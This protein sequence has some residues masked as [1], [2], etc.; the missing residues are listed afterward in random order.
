MPRAAGQPLRPIS[1]LAGLVVAITLGAACSPSTGSSRR[2]D[3]PRVD[4]PARAAAPTAD[5]VNAFGTDLLRGVADLEDGN[6]AITPYT[7]ARVLAMSRVGARDR[8]RTELD[9]VLHVAGMADVDEGFNALDA[10][11]AT[12]EGTRESALRRGR[13]RLDSST[14]LWAQE[15][16]RFDPSFLDV[17]SSQYDTGMRTVDFLSDP[18]EATKAVN[19]WVANDTD[20]QVEDLVPRGTFSTATRF[21][22]AS[23]FAVRAP[24]LVPFPGDDAVDAPFRLADGRAVPVP[25]MRASSEGE[26]RTGRGEGWEAIELPYVGG[27]L[28]M[29]VVVPDQNTLDT[30]VDQLTGDELE[31]IVRSLRR[32]PVEVSLPSF[33]FTTR[34]SLDDALTAIGLGVA[35]AEGEADFSGIT[36]DEPLAVSDVP[37]QTFVSAGPEGSDADA[38]TV[39]TIGSGR[40]PTAT[41]FTVDRPFLVVVRDVDT[42]AILQLGLVVDPR[43]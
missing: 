35:F 12:R 19:R 33:A 28:A 6:V 1:W 41:R 43:R 29:L 4:A 13:I 25:T 27:E 36:T 34:L 14:S 24:W 31:R 30:F 5:A 10:A 2:S 23:A 18:E 26:L 17:L 38:T 21:V 32:A 39:V 8:T 7:T 9:R 42:G 11:L 40:R 37:H 20:G 16:T 15:D 3:E 22:A